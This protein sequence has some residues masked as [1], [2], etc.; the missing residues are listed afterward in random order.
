[1]SDFSGMEGFALAAWQGASHSMKLEGMPHSRSTR[2]DG[3]P[4]VQPMCP[5]CILWTGDMA[6]A[7]KS[8]DRSPAWSPLPRPKLSALP[9][10][11]QVFQYRMNLR[12]L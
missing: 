12:R 6:S 5:E 7:L 8:S 2:S 10:F 9:E 11:K 4:S 3:L 1:M